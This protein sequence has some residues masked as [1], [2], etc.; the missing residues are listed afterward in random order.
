VYIKRRLMADLSSFAIR[1]GVDAIW[2]SA[3]IKRR[4]RDIV[5]WI[6]GPTL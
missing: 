1:T 4:E 3:R 5:V 6:V 2:R